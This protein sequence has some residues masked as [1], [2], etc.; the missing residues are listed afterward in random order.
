MNEAQSADR[1]VEWLGQ[2]VKKAGAKGVVFGLSGGVD[3]SVA[4]VLCK[5][6]FPDACLALAMPCNSHESDLLHAKAVVQNFRIPLKVIDLSK[7]FGCILGE[8]GEGRCDER[9]NE[10]ANIKPRL[11]MLCLYHFANKLNCLVVGTGNKS[12]LMTGYFTKFGDGAA[13]L[14]P[15]GALYKGEVKKLAAHLGIAKEIIEKQPSAGLWKGQTD[16]SELG[17]SYEELDK[18]IEAIENGKTKGIPKK[19]LVVVR[20]MIAG[21]EHKRRMPPICK[22][23]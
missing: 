8:L 21:S 10:I 18:M 23:H 7:P 13:D 9:K 19:S 5:R 11:R 12:E 4:G 16:Q 20:K 14:L 2:Q 17:F 15:L 3:S 22:I 6:A 1:I